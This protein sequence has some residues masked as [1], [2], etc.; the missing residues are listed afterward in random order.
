MLNFV[1]LAFPGCVVTAVNFWE[2]YMVSLLIVVTFPIRVYLDFCYFVHMDVE[3]ERKGRYLWSLSFWDVSKSRA[4]LSGFPFFVPWYFMLI[5][6]V[7]LAGVYA[8]F[9]K[10]P[11]GFS[12]MNIGM[13]V[14]VELG[15]LSRL[16][17]QL[18]LRVQWFLSTL[19]HRNSF[20]QQPRVFIL[21]EKFI[22]SSLHANLH[23]AVKSCLASFFAAPCFFL[24][25]FILRHYHDPDWSKVNYILLLVIGGVGLGT[26]WVCLYSLFT[27][28]RDLVRRGFWVFGKNGW[29][30]KRRM[31]DQEDA[32]ILS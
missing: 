18:F 29:A 20:L 2:D 7:I 1:V 22:I 26:L 31:H 30:G 23:P 8:A 10:A 9:T 28:S 16:L 15:Y 5:D 27:I 11:K 13:L 14:M 24:S 17:L 25:Y 21:A 6:L 32:F 3:V 19:E 4:T 12:V